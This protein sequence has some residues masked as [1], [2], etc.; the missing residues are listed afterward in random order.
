M[1]FFNPA[2]LLDPTG[3]STSRFL[4]PFTRL[5]DVGLRGLFVRTVTDSRVVRVVLSVLRSVAV[6]FVFVVVFVLG[7]RVCVVVAGG[8]LSL[9]EAER[10][11]ALDD[12]MDFCTGEVVVA[13]HL[14]SRTPDR[15]RRAFTFTF[16]FFDHEFWSFDDGGP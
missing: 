11:C 10:W 2:S 4:L 9:P 15:L 3:V 5:S 6:E 14:S 12:M 7:L 16:S 1:L 13:A 8:F